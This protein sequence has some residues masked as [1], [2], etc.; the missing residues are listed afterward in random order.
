M[1]VSVG[2]LTVIL[3][4]TVDVRAEVSVESERR[5]PRIYVGRDRLVERTITDDG[6]D[7]SGGGDLV[8]RAT[9]DVGDVEV[10]R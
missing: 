9:V 1:S 4:P 8:I 3:P 5:R 10:R 7:G 2:D 6:V